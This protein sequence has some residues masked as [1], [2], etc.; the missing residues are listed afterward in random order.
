MNGLPIPEGVKVLSVGELTA[1]VKG[2]LEDAF[3]S[4]WVAG[5]VSNCRPA[6]SRHIY[7]TLKD[8][9]AQVQAVIWRTT[10]QWLRFQPTDGLQVIARG[11]LDVYPPAGAYKLIVQELHPRGLGARE[12]ALRQLKEKL[13]R[14]GWFD[15]RRKKPLP[16][17]PQR[18]ALVTS[19]GGAAVRDMLEILTRRWPAAEVWVCPVRVQG[20]GAAEDIARMIQLLNRLHQRRRLTVDVMVVGRG[21]GSSE[22]LWAFNEECVARAIVESVVPVVSAVGHE[23]DVTIAD[24]VADQRALTPSEA[25]TRIVPDRL[26]L[27]AGLADLEGRLRSALAQRLDLGRRR[28]EDLAGRRVFRLPLERVRFQE[29]RLDGWAERL[30]RA[31]QQRLDRGRQALEARSARLEN[32]SPLNVLARGYSLTRKLT[33]RAIVRS[34]DQLHSGDRLETTLSHGRVV[35]RVE[36]V[37]NE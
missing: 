33:D 20:D 3:P 31:M 25:A 18:L 26:E 27:L 22:D 19:P 6:S 36:E 29:Q 28:L 8:S 14:L 2:L 1:A 12:L 24:L 37:H 16:R 9:A 35:S 7:F 30:Q 32:L 23:I 21:G 34:A 10:A 4:V 11:R 15:P 13:A 5:E 17:W